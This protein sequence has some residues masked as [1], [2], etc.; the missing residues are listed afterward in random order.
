MSTKEPRNLLNPD[1]PAEPEITRVPWYIRIYGA[2]CLVYGLGSFISIGLFF[3]LIGWVLVNDPSAISIG[4]NPTLALILVAF[5][6]V[7]GFVASG[8]LVFF[9]VSLIR[10][11]RRHAAR[12]A[13]VL[14]VFTLIQ[15]VL[16]IMIGGIQLSLL[17]PV[18]QLG[19]LIALSA[20][21]DPTLRQERELQRHLRDVLC[22][23]IHTPQDDA[24]LGAAGRSALEGPR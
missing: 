18:I 16:E 22:G 10:S 17:R 8:I 2:L 14:I 6:A 12:W 5:G 7:I 4:S 13:Y 21:V 24:V 20:T 3:G 11:R 23:R 1:L 15:I 9:G 19:I